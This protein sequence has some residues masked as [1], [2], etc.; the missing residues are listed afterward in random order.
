M[1]L[2]QERLKVVDDLTEKLVIRPLGSPKQIALL[3]KRSQ[4][5]FDIVVIT[6]Q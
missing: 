6:P 3:F 4:K 2:I 1:M 5:G